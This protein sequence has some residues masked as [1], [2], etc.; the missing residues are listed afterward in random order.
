MIVAGFGCR[1]SANADDLEAALLAAI[2]AADIDISAICGFA[3]ANDKAQEAG[4]KELSQR[5]A[6]P[7]LAIDIQKLQ[8]AA[9]HTITK[10][11]A[12]M[13]AKG[14]PSIAETAALAAAGP[15]SRLLA[16]RVTRG[17]AA[18]ALAIGADA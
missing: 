18:C 10:S 12:V 3:T 16:Q 14:V 1:K 7:I 5:H 6:L 9:T 4:L 11:P 13:A 17:A 15:A 2:K 8:S